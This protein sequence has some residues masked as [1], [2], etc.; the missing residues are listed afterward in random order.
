MIVGALECI[1]LSTLY[2]L[3][4]FNSDLKRATNQEN[5]RVWM[6]SIWVIIPGILLSLFVYNFVLEF[7]GGVS[8][9]ISSQP[10]WS[11]GIFGWFF[12]VL[13]PF[14]FLLPFGLVFPWAPEGDGHVKGVMLGMTNISGKTEAP[15]PAPAPAVQV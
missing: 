3:R 5:W 8:E 13:I 6:Y 2:G 9:S 15:A 4:R 11:V 10:A 1:V 12:C 14:V 7:N